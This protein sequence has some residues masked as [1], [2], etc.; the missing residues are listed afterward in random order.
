MLTHIIAVNY[1]HTIANT[2]ILGCCSKAI[3]IVIEL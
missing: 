2:D 3:I 1:D